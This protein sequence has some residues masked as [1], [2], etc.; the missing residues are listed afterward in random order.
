[1]SGR[2]VVGGVVAFLVGLALLMPFAGAAGAGAAGGPVRPLLAWGFNLDGELGD[3]SNTDAGIPVA[4]RLPRGTRVVQARAGCDHAIALTAAGRVLAWGDDTF[5]QLGDGSDQQRFTPVRVKLPPGGSK[6]ISI[7]A[8]CDHNLALT[9]SGRVFAWGYN[10]D[11][12]LGDG[13]TTNR[14]LP[15]KVRFP[16]GTRIKSISAGYGDSLAVTTSGRVLAWGDNSYGQ[17]GDGNFTGVARKPLSVKLPGGVKIAEVACGAFHNLAVTT[18]GLVYGWGYNAH[19]ELGDKSVANA[20]LPV[21]VALPTGTRVSQV[22]AGVNH[23]VA[24]TAAGHVLAWGF[25]IYGQLGDG[26]T[27]PVSRD[28]PV[29]VKFSAPVKIKAIGAGRDHAVVITTAGRVLAWGYNFYGQLGNGGL[30]SSARPV[31][32]RL[33]QGLRPLALGLGPGAEFSLLI[34]H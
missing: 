34:V 13:T 20:D 25:D 8:G 1:M 7:S 19:G 21:R 29:R 27:A 30:A 4:V 26:T 33:K 6:I 10:I 32:V 15:V 28:V 22:S 12:E 11:G 24:L 5:G 14:A 17:L 2:R 23:S 9:S 3:G 18:T 16:T 31:P